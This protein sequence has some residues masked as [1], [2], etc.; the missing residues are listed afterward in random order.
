MKILHVVAGRGDGGL[1]RHVLSLTAA[2][3][4]TDTVTLVAHESFR[5]R[6]SANVQFLPLDLTR[7]R[8]SP[9][10]RLR[11]RAMLQTV[12]P[13]IVHTHANK[14]TALVASVRLPVR[15][16]LIAT[17][18]G[19]KRNTRM[20]QRC[21]A[22][23][24]VSHGIAAR[25]AHPRVEVIY[26]GVAA[27]T[28]APAAW[29]GARPLVLAVGRL[30]PVKGF[31][32]LLMAW[33]DMPGQLV[34]IGDGPERARLQRMA[35]GCANAALWGYRDDVMAWLLAAD[36]VVIP[37]RREG[38]PLVLA[39]A[40]LA[41]RVVVSTQVPGVI[42]W[43]PHDYLVASESPFLLRETLRRTLHDLSAAQAAFRPIWERARRELTIDNMT[44][45]TRA[46]YHSLLA[47]P[48][49]DF[50]VDP[51]YGRGD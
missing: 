29:D 22:I 31:D 15:C 44:Q 40:L 14:A 48:S 46:V 28:A 33:Q 47:E 24:A 11:V 35:V 26:N 19:L 9:R 4:R 32:L 25:I 17:V 20:Y 23:I 43:L 37:S 2:L 12:Q 30:A 16:K 6:V 21:D 41:R 1:E 42:E 51:S 49:P 27:Q 45:R 39:E 8:W 18:H 5:S 3:A 10:L 13:D 38:F 36:L 50:A 7:S 34:I